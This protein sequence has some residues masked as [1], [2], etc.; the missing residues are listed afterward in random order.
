VP[1][2]PQQPFEAE[3]ESEEEEEEHKP[4]LGDEARH[5]RR[6]DEREHLRLVRPQE[7]PGEEIGRDR[8]EPETARDEPE[9]G[10]NGNGDRE[11]FEGHL[12]L[13]PQ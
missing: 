5:V 9:R 2:A 3:L 7:E 13:I 11:L 1:A 6:L 12:E 4:E 8:G 10:E